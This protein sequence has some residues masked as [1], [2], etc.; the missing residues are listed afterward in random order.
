ME[1][2]GINVELQEASGIILNQVDNKLMINTKLLED[3]LNKIKEE[4]YGN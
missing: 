3:Y 2:L 4:V 1:I